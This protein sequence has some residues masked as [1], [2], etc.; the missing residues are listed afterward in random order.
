MKLKIL[1]MIDYSLL[2]CVLLLST[3]GILFIYS[4]G[5]NSDGI[6]VT[7]E[8]IKQIIW[9]VVG[10]IFMLVLGLVDYRKFLRYAPYMY[11]G[12]VVM[13]IYT[14]LFGSKVNGA[15]SWI[16]I[17]PFGIQPSEIGKFF[18]IL[19]LAWYLERSQNEKPKK[20]FL[21]A[22][23]IMLLPMGLIL[24]QPDMGT[25]SV[26]LPIFIVMCFMAG[27]P[28]R[29]LM[30]V[31]FTGF[32]TIIF[33]VLPVWETEILRKSV[34]A[35]HI[36]TNTKLLL[37]V[38]GTTTAI[39]IIGI[40]GQIFLRRKYFYWITFVF[41]I[42]TVSLV[43]SIAAGKV[44]KPYQLQR[45]IVFIDP[46]CDPLGSGWNIIQSKTAIGSGNFFG[47]G[48]KQ[49]TQSHYRFLPQQSTDFIFSILSEESGFIGGMFVFVIYLLILLR[50]THIARQTTNYY[51]TLICSGFLGMLYFHFIVNVGMVMGIM[52]ITGIPLPFLSYGGSALLTNMMCMG[53]VMSINYRRLDFKMP[54]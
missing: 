6:L 3:F 31:I 34:P 2:L 36:L 42:I 16:G 48:Y 33:T 30:M 26:Y 13:L 24:I 51:G 54:V 44:L 19:T 9:L 41:G 46:N 4:S 17:G 11:A 18:Y 32:T 28:L 29:Y 23:G 7:N 35:I 39:A 52:P 22:T 50:I 14:L 38:I 5:I 49:G 47:R 27:V 40:I 8:Y 20:R 12:L 53:L 37:L 43:L 21:I 1:N 45:L 25:A 15:R 10:I